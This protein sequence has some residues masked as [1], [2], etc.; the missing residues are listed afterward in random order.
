MNVMSLIS[1]LKNSSLFKDSFWAL[2]GNVISKGLTLVA[3]III[4]RLLGS[5]AYGEYGMI[6][7]TLV[8][9]AVFSTFGLGFTATKFIAQNK[10]VAPDRLRGLVKAALVVSLVFSGFM[11]LVVFAFA[12]QLAVYLEDPSMTTTLRYTAIVIVF[13]SLATVQIGIMAGLKQFRKTALINVTVGVITFVSSI[14]LAYYYGLEG[15]VIA[16][17]I[18]NVANCLLNYIVLRKDITNYPTGESK[19]WYDIKEQVKFSFPIAIQESS[20][21]ITFWASN[22]LLLKMADYS[23]LG[24]HSAATQWTA[25]ILFI[26]SVLQNVMLSYF[27]ESAGSAGADQHKMLKRMLLIN[28][29]ATFI[30]FLVCLAISPYVVDL[31]GESYKGLALVL[32]IAMAA[33]IFRCQVQVFIQEFIALGKPWILCGIRLG[34][35]V[36]S[37]LLSAL[38]IFNLKENAAALYNASFLIASAF[39]LSLMWILYNK[40]SKSNK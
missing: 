7:N 11:A 17:L 14:I 22:L 29:L 9:I 39:C 25:I 3:G 34:R 32:N 27:S 30:P 13:N 8:Y 15:T 23:Q 19:L 1:K 2:S 26:P 38:L 6:K 28:F 4:A 24:L 31:Y 5:E 21:S 36:V 10:D 33:T 20:Y 16:L 40:L 18:T 37:L 35:D 12:H